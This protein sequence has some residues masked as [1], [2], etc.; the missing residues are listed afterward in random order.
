MA[1][2]LELRDV[3]IAFTGRADRVSVI[4]D[5]LD[6][7]L[8]AGRMH[9]VTGG[10]GT[11]K[12]SVLRVATGLL[13]P[14]AGS[15]IWNGEELGTL[16]DDAVSSRR[17][18]LV[19]YVDQQAALIDELSVLENV[20]LPAVPRRAA[21]AL[22]PRALDL[23]DEYGV[24]ELAALRPAELTAGERA[25]VAVV[26]SLLLEPPILVLDEPTANLDRAGADELIALLLRLRAN[27]A[28][29]LVA[30]QEQALIDAADHRSTLG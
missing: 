26:R 19:G 12:T 9:C 25:R 17:G 15:V 13:R 11:G 14:T 23:L 10:R 29:I 3:A 22:G 27:G 5:R 24:A 7:G 16:S 4:A 18:G 2:L 28:A 6:I 30:S 20:L 1:M 21:A 8:R